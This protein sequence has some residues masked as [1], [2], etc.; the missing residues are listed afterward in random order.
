MTE[1][2]NGSGV[3]STEK[4]KRQLQSPFDTQIE[5]DSSNKMAIKY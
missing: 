2:V 4:A 3:E 5:L 1:M